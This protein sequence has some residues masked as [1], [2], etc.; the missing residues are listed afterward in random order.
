MSR[1]SLGLVGANLYGL[2]FQKCMS[3]PGCQLGK[4]SATPFVV[5]ECSE[6]LHVHAIKSLM[7]NRPNAFEESDREELFGDAVDGI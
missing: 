5:A 2:T 1:P 6:L 3:L 7:C 4:M